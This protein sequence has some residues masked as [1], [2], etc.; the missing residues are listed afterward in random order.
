[1]LSA[2]RRED[3]LRLGPAAL[4]LLGEDQAPVRDHVELTLRA[5]DGRRLVLRARPDLGRETRSPAVVA[6]S[7]GAVEDLDA[8]GNIMPGA[9]AG[10]HRDDF[11]TPLESQQS[12]TSE[13]GGP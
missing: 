3:L 11:S 1:M 13:K 6:V 5:L 10:R 8:H 9:A 12:N 2:E 4:M 7:D